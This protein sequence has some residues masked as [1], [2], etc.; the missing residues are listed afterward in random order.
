MR[1]YWIAVAARGDIWRF[2]DLCITYC[3]YMDKMKVRYRVVPKQNKKSSFY[4]NCHSQHVTIQ[5]A[6]SAFPHYLVLRERL[7]AWYKEKISL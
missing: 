2:R 3:G 1:L 5:A 4:V 7:S 6:D